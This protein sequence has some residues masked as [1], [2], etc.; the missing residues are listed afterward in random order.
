MSKR[1]DT[2]YWAKVDELWDWYYKDCRNEG[3]RYFASIQKASTDYLDIKNDLLV[4]LN[5]QLAEAKERR[6]RNV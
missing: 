3:D 1:T 2:E 6:D 4:T 5:N